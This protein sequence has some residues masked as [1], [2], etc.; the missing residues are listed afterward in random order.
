MPENSYR[1]FQN[2]GCVYFPCHKGI[3]TEK[4]NCMYCFC[5]QYLIR[6]CV[7]NPIWLESN[8]LK[9]CSK[10][11][12]NHGPNSYEAIVDRCDWLNQEFR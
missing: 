6:D 2:K 5:P 9:D 3:A 12:V 10:C 1:F 4:F 8:G 11:L 7:G